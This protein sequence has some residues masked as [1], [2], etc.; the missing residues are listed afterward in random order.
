M[1]EFFD[2]L[3]DK[4]NMTGVTKPRSLVHQDGNWHKSVHVWIF[5]GDKLL[6]QKRSPE[7]DSHPNEWDISC[8]G[9]VTAGETSLEA[10][11]KEIK[12]ELD[13]DVLGPDFKLLFS[14]KSQSVQKNGTFINNEFNDV[15]LVE[16]D[17]DISQI[18]LQTEEV[19]EVKWVSISELEDVAK[20][21]TTGYVPHPEE[22]QKLVSYL[23]EK[24]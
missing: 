6:M 15:Y 13:L 18:K 16:R 22:Y 24:L 21:K 7:K 4:G 14:L 11:I 17:L 9:H 12:E 5:N 2:V 1:K 8:A 3:D 19:S 10:A 20:N 23:K